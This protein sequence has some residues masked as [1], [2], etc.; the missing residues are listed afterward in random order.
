MIPSPWIALAALL[1][2]G[3]SACAAPA[4]AGEEIVTWEVAPQRVDCTGEMPQRCLLVREPPAEEWTRFYDDIDGFTH[5]EG[6]RYR[7]RVARTRRPDP[8]ADASA[9]AYRLV[10]VI[11]KT[12]AAP[13][14]TLR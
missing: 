11:S 9:F 10:D 8:P 12:R 6:H 5:E 3:A 7:I 2:L 14:D 4:D 1:L 13:G